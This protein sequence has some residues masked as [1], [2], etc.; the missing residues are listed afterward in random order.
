MF[1]SCIPCRILLTRE[2]RIATIH[3]TSYETVEAEIKAAMPSQRARGDENR[4]GNKPPNGPRRAQSKAESRV[5]CDVGAYVSCREY[6]SIPQSARE[7]VKQ[8]GTANEI[9]PWQRILSGIFFGGDQEMKI[10]PGLEELAK[11][12]ETGLYKVV[13]VHC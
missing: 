11:Y 13:P 9:R 4:A 10:M 2:T 6:E 12:R 7:T 1:F 5:F 8:G 3:L